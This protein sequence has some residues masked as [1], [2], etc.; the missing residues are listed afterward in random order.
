SPGP[1]CSTGSRFVYRLLRK[2]P[3]S[4]LSWRYLALAKYRRKA[5]AVTLSTPFTTLFDV[6]H[7]IVC[8]GMTRVGTPGLIAATAEAGALGLLRAPTAAT[9]EALVKPTARGRARPDR[10]SGVNSPTLPPRTPPPWE[11]YMRATVE[12]GVRGGETGG[13]TPEPS[14]PL[15]REGGV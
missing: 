8:G 6:E 14:L 4:L 5:S 7:P 9:P 10:P 2:W 11:E 3:P 13:Q 1:R 15:F 12:S